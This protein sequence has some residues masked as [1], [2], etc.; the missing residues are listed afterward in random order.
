MCSCSSKSPFLLSRAD[1]SVSENDVP[2]ESNG[3]SEFGRLVVKEMNR[4]GN[5]RSK[6][7]KKIKRFKD[8]FEK[9]VELL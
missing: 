9:Q 3:L 1:S 4:L 7:S 8:V 5:E 2:A 6:K